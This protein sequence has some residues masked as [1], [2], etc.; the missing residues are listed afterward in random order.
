MKTKRIEV[1]NFKAVKNNSVDFNGCSAIITGGNNK[2]KSSLLKGLFDRFRGEKPELILKDGEEK[3][4]SILELTDGSIIEWVFNE[5]TEKFIYITKDGIKQTTGV[6]SMLGNKYFGQK[7]DI[8]KFLNSTPKEQIKSLQKLVGLD[9]TE[10]ENKYKVAYDERTIA[11]SEL[12]KL[13]NQKVDKPELVEKPEI[14]KFKSVLN[15]YN[16]YNLKLREN[17]KSENEKHLQEIEKFNEK[18]K[19]LRQTIE[20]KKIAL[21]ELEYTAK[22]YDVWSYI[23]NDDLDTFINSMKS[24]EELKSISNLP[25][26]DYKSTLKIQNDIDNAN[27]Q[28]RKYDAYERDLIAY[29]NWVEAGKQAK[30]NAENADKKVKE[31]EQEKLNLIKSANIPA[32]FEITENGLL[33][34]GLP[35]SNNQLSSSSKYIAALKLGYLVLG[36]IKT[37]HFDASFLDNNSL[38]EIKTWA[39]S[40]DLQLLIERPDFD[41]GEIKYEIIKN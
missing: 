29:D 21:T 16:E 17:W 14:E 26:P 25:E 24:P 37:M 1:S 13:R 3:G 6:L 41:G 20:F 31:I 22:K 15:E 39:E 19:Q 10:I 23:L 27:E 9:F 7:F 28:L 4:Y 33:Y 11:N 12:T 18:Q 2:G 8:D 35:L 30:I 40:I 5:K 34:N 36:E 38:S 32:E